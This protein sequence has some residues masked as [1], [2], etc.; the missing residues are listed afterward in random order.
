MKD[1]LILTTLYAL[2]GVLVIAVFSLISQEIAGDGAAL[3]AG[4]IVAGSVVAYAI[5]AMRRKR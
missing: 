1:T 4:L 5:Q 2:A 3:V